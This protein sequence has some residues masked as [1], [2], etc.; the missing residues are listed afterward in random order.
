MV[1]R[2]RELH[3]LQTGSPKAVACETKLITDLPLKVQVNSSPSVTFLCLHPGLFISNLSSLW[4]QHGYSRR[5][6][7]WAISCIFP[8]GGIFI[9][10]QLTSRACHEVRRCFCLA[11]GSGYV[12]VW[13]ILP[14]YRC[15]EE[16]LGKF[17]FCEWEN[18]YFVQAGWLLRGLSPC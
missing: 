8:V 13:G 16:V 14:N 4:R 1:R 5:W 7:M 18:V 12:C 2:N 15:E 6:T 11:S 17:M 10:K 9:A 3:L